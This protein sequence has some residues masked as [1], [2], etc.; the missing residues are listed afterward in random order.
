MADEKGR[1]L[2]VLPG[3]EP[4]WNRPDVFAERLAVAQEYRAREHVDLA[5]TI[6]DVVLAGDP[7]SRKR[8]KVGER[9][10]KHCAAAMADMNGAGRVGGDIFD[11]DRGAPSHVAAAIIRS[12]EDRAQSVDPGC[13]LEGEIDESRTGDLHLRQQIIASKLCGN[14]LGQFSKSRPYCA[15]SA[16]PTGLR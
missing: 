5:S 12:L 2:Y 16:A 7:K 14:L 13:R 15:A 11:I 9:I 3:I 10:A 8:E 1:F 4:L 6:V